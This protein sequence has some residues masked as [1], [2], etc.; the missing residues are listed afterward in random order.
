MSQENVD[1]LRKGYDVLNRAFETGSFSPVLEAFVDPD[2]DWRATENAVDDV[3]G[4]RGHDA[5]RRYFED[6]TDLFDEL[7]LTPDEL[8]DLDNERVMATL[9]MHGRA[10]QSGIETELT[11]AVVFTMRDGR[12]VK[13][14]E[15]ATKK[16]AL[17]AVGLSERD[18]HA[19]S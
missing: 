13:A 6:W 2:I 1:I 5:I 12:L 3:G 18:A 14:R 7:T 16:E 17:E 11:F 15:Y 8:T 19:D 9:R 4:M 10:K